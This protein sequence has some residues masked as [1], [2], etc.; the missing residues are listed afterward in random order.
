[1]LLLDAF[2]ITGKK[3]P[4]ITQITQIPN[5][6]LCNLRNLWFLFFR[7]YRET[8]GRKSRISSVGRPLR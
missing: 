6:N 8:W 4:Q 7:L 5:R 2:G 3:K 1:M